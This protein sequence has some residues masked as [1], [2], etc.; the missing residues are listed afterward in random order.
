MPLTSIL[1]KPKNEPQP[2]TQETNQKLENFKYL[3]KKNNV[4]ESLN[5]IV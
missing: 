1:L 4:V 3:K 2:S 5:Q